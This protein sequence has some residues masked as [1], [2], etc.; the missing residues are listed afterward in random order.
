VGAKACWPSEIYGSIGSSR[1]SEKEKV[2]L[3]ARGD[4]KRLFD[5][6]H[7]ARKQFELLRADLKSGQRFLQVLH[8]LHRVLRRDLY[9]AGSVFAK[10]LKKIADEGDGARL[11]K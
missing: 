10:A 7:D 6:I 1:F 8:P 9:D 4:V 3:P 2:V 5:R 11:P